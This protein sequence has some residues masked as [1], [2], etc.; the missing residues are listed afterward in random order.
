MLLVQIIN[1]ILFTCLFVILYYRTMMLLTFLHFFIRLF[2]WGSVSLF[3]H[4]VVMCTVFATQ[5][6]GCELANASAG[7]F[8]QFLFI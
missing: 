7:L 6:V 8:Q 5:K 2:A 1:N 4:H 3:R